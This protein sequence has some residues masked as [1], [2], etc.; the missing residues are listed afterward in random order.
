VANIEGG[1]QSAAGKSKIHEQY[2][3]KILCLSAAM[4]AIVAAG[5]R[6]DIGIVD[7]NREKVRP[8]I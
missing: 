1:K 5:E 4:R 6:S 8:L 2:D 3:W 7:Q